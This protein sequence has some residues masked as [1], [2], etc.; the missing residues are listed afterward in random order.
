[1][2]FQLI[3][4]SLEEAKGGGVFAG[5]G[6]LLFLYTILLLFNDIENNLNKIWQVSKGRS[7]RTKSNRLLSHGHCHPHLF[8]SR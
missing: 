6:I 1:L 7:N 3:E 2:L 8:Y 4:N 5:V